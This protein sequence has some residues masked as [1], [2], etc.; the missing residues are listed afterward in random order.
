MNK[1]ILVVI[2]DVNLSDSSTINSLINSVEEIKGDT[3]FVWDNSKQI[4]EYDNIKSF[5]NDNGVRFV[6]EHHPENLPLSRLYNSVIQR[7]NSTHDYLFLFDHDSTFDKRFF[8]EVDKYKNRRIH[9]FLPIVKYK[10]KIVSPTR[11]IFLKGFYFNNKPSGFKEA[12]NISAI[13]SGM[14]ISFEFLRTKF[15]GYDERL[16]FYG[17][18]DYFMMNY[19]KNEEKLF[20]LNY[21]FEHDLTLS[22]LNQPSDKL[23]NSYK[24]MLEAWSVIYSDSSLIYLVKMYSVVHSMYTAFKFK[25]K[26]FLLWK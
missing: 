4:Q 15:I 12:S 5:F 6:Y 19:C 10:N 26:R 21:E 20:I 3:I 11:K 17:T 8:L 25:N 13:N 9:L 7:F 2:Y 22:T 18:D 23:I 16:K 24:Q 1:L 14:V